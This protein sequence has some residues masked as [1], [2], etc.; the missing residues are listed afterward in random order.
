MSKSV[1]PKPTRRTY[2]HG[3]L[4][5][6]LV[7][8]ANCILKDEGLDALTLRAA[9]QRAGVSHAA[10]AHH[11][12]SLQGLLTAVAAQGF[13]HFHA[14]LETAMDAAPTS[15]LERLRAAGRAYVGFAVDNPALIQL[16][17]S[18]SRL[19]WSDPDLC[20]AS[21]RAYRQLTDIVRPAA[22]RLGASGEED[23]RELALMVWSSVHGYAHLAIS[24]ALDR[25]PAGARPPIPDLPG[26]LFGRWKPGGG[27]RI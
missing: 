9:A 6:A 21:D 10:P 7:A 16:M 17:F 23:I 24:G 25:G 27:V 11:V 4:R 3:D 5:Q 2:H 18:G 19:D 15:P 20:A 14:S 8:A 26:L 1:P 12:G 13:V 22:E